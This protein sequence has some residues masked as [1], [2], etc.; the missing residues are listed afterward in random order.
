MNDLAFYSVLQAFPSRDRHELV[1]V[2]L[3]ILRDGAW[4]VR[5]LPSPEK[6]LALNPFFPTSGLV[7][8]RKTVIA[9]LEGA[10]NFEVARARFSRYGNDPGLQ[11]F[12][13]QFQAID[14]AQ[15]ESRVSLIM[16]RLVLPPELTKSVEVKAKVQSRLRIKLRR[17]FKNEGLFS[18]NVEDIGNHKV[19]GP[20]PIIAEQGLF[21]EFALKNGAMHITETID[22][23]VQKGS[24][25]SKSL[26]AQAKTLILSAATKQFG[27]DT[28]RYI[29]ISGSQRKHAKPSIN[30]LDEQGDVFAVES[31]EDMGRYF[32]LIH[33]AASAH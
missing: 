27:Q 2:G 3:V 25:R 7:N 11:P 29:I 10:S 4:D 24:L 13:G 6:L 26:E 31:S 33:S 18:N 20:Y 9:M 14:D 19:V 1:A 12:V 23:D 5:M 15:Y 8:I 16:Q 30:L 32:E 22:F 21:A 17:Q 28:K